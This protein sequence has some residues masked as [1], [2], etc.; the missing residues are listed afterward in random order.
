M[1]ILLSIL[2]GLTIFISSNAQVGI[3]TT[4]PN[5]LAALEIQDTARGL[6]IP[7]LTMVQ[8]LAI[9][10]PPEGLMVYQKDST[11]GFWHFDGVQWRNIYSSSYTNSVGGK[12][13]IIIVDSVTNAQAQA[14]I[15]SDF[16]PIRRK[17]TFIVVRNLPV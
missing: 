10:S 15:A 3:G 13:K 2:S 14:I 12:N 11:K 8:R 4:T 17:F 6:L 1:K 9:Q 16:G 7:R 5:N